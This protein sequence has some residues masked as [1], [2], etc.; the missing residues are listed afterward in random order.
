MHIYAHHTQSTGHYSPHTH[1]RLHIKTLQLCYY[2]CIY[3]INEYILLLL[4]WCTARV[5]TVSVATT[6]DT[7]MHRYNIIRYCPATLIILVYIYIYI[8]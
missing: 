1:T 7:R 3:S 6:G 2:T 8:Y 4:N 5:L